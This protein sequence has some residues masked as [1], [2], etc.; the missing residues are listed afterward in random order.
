MPI[1]HFIDW[2]VVFKQASGSIRNVNSNGVSE[3][4]INIW[5]INFQD[6]FVCSCD[7]RETEQ[8]VS[9]GHGSFIPAIST[10]VHKIFLVEKSISEPNI[11]EETAG[12][13]N[14][15]L[16]L[17]VPAGKSSGVFLCFPSESSSVDNELT[18]RF[19][20]NIFKYVCMIRFCKLF[21]CFHSCVK[22]ICNRK[23]Y[24]QSICV[25]CLYRPFTA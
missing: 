4:F 8:H 9:K 13:P 23:F 3:K 24:K 20:K 7:T 16:E 19:T 5:W 2:P 1:A 14:N 21:E 25:T 10:G 22:R 18:L 17:C 11:E 6:F 12:M 15:K